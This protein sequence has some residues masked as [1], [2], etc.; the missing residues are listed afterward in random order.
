MKS[1]EKAQIAALAF[2]FVI[3]AVFVAE[4]R[5]FARAPDGSPASGHTAAKQPKTEPAKSAA[6]PNAGEEANMVS[7]NDNFVLL[8]GGAF[9]M[10]SPES[11]RQRGADEALHEVTLSSF[12]ADP[13]EVTQGDYEAVMGANPSHFK[14]K[15]LP[16]ENVTWYNAI[17]YC[18]RLSE[19]RG[20]APVYTLEGNKVRWDRKANGYRL[21]TE[22]E[23]EYAARAGTTTVFSAGNQITS[24][25]ANFQGSYPYL[26]EENYVTHRD[27]SVVTSSS[28]GETISVDSLEPNGFGLY[29]AHGNVSEWCFDYYGPYELGQAAD[30]AGAAS[31]SL[32]ANRGGGYND[33]AK[34]LRSAYRSATN[35]VDSGQNLGFRIARNAQAGE[36]FV[37]TTYSLDIQMPEN[38]RI[39]IAFFSYSG[40]T[41]SAARIIQQKTGADI[42]KIEMENPYRGNIYEASQAHLNRNAHPPLR[43]RV[44]NMAQYDVILL[45]Y[46]TWWAT[47]PMPVFSFV[48]SYDF[49]G[50]TIIPFCSHGGTMYGDSVSDLSKLAPNSYVGLGLE[51][52]YSGGRG[53][54]G[55]I[56]EWLAL[57]GIKEK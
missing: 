33:F 29:N 25:N 27:S 51:F 1:K 50:K 55:K 47:M 37:E 32:R 8:D 10:G 20:L 43:T 21:L 56:S 3:L 35:P 38:P 4:P 24:A 11:E 57:S 7:A 26:I 45:G 9:A 6:P 22:A 52:N 30:P 16:V 18:N 42:V 12:Y 40:N 28:R 46:P 53:L 48:E 31:G 5:L 39:L 49:G 13:C 34:H 36:G 44:E 54:S 19:S 15:S 14:G 23:W 41:E 17:E 2:T